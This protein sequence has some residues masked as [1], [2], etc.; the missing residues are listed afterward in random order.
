[1][2]AFLGF[3]RPPRFSP[4]ILNVDRAGEQPLVLHRWC[5]TAVLHRRGQKHSDTLLRVCACAEEGDSGWV[6][7]GLLVFDELPL[8][9]FARR[10]AAHPPRLVDG[11]DLRGA[12][13]RSLRGYTCLGGL[14]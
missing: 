8:D 7:I 3:P 4:S 9:P 5:S 14:P 6:P 13:L 2:I 12:R 11:S 10:T 1:M